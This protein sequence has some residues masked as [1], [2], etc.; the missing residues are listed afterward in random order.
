MNIVLFAFWGML[1][2]LI[3]AIWELFLST[4]WQGRVKYSTTHVEICENVMCMYS[5]SSVKDFEQTAD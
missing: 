2:Y 3:V 4:F 1:L 5:S